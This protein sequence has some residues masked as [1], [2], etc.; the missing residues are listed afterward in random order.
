MERTD[1]NLAT[2]RVSVDEGDLQAAAQAGLITRQQAQALWAHWLPRALGVQGDAGEPASGLAPGPRFSFTH[3]LYY[4]GGLVAIG[5]MTLFMNLGWEKFGDA[6]L[7]LIGLGYLLLSL[8]VA[9]H[10]E[11]KGLGVPAGIMATLAVCLVP[12]V[13]WTVQHMLGYWPDGNGRSDHYRDYHRYIDWRWLLMELAT[14]A[15]GVVMLWRHRRPFM[16]MPLAFTLWYLSMDVADMLMQDGR[17]DWQ[18]R[19]DVTLVFGLFTCALALWVEMRC[20]MAR[21]AVWRQDFAF[22]LHFWGAIMAWGGLSLHDSNSEVDKAIYALINIGL[23]FGGAALR[24]RVYTVLGAFGVAGYLGHL[25]WK[26]FRDSM[27]FPF[28]LTLLGLAVIAL[29]IWWQRHEKAIEAR[30]QSW[31]PAALRRP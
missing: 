31:L 23:V 26:V 14:L 5:A 8:K 16:V 30:M 29:G 9:T 3:V 12:L 15:A 17:S 20:R 22:W 18:F 13:V 10:L 4:F 6:G 19:R 2:A 11:S 21:D 28:A 27:M 24:R 1:A 7:L 25:S